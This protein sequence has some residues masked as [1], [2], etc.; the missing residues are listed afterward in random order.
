MA[1]QSSAKVIMNASALFDY[2]LDA[3]GISAID[4]HRNAGTGRNTS[5]GIAPIIPHD[6]IGIVNLPSITID[7]CFGK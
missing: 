1:S 3:L 2:L 5:A 6:D 7:L 4:R